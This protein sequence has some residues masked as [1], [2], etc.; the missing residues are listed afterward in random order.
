MLTAIFYIY[1]IAFTFVFALYTKYQFEDEKAGWAKSKGQ[2]HKYGLLMRLMVPG[3]FVV[4]NYI[5]FA[6]DDLLLAGAIC[7]P[8]WDILI[9][10]IALKTSWFYNGS[11]STTDKT[12]KGIKW[13]AYAGILIGSVV[14]KFTY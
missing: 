10:K 11:T 7:M 3:A 13:I 9:N 1:N 14:I 4:A 8:L 2:W 5:N 6:L 12:M